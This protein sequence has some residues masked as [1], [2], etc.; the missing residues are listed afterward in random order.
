MLL[1]NELYDKNHKPPKN[2]LLLFWNS[3]TYQMFVNFSNLIHNE[4]GLDL[5]KQFYTSKFGWSYK[6]CKS[7]IDVINNVHILNDGFMI[8][9]IIVKSESDVEKAISYINSLFTPEFIDKIEQKIIQRNQKQR[10]RSKRLL[11]REKNEKN[12]FLENVNPK[13]LNKFIWSPRISQSKIR[14]LYQTNAKGICDD[15][16][17][18]EVGFTLYARCLQGRDEH[19]LANEGK[20]KCHHCRKVNISPS[21][22]LIICSC[23]YAY[24]FREYM[25]SFNKDGMLS[26]SATPFFNK[27]IDMWS[28]ANTYYDKIKAIDFVIHECHLNM[29]S[30]VTRGFAGRNLIEGTGEQLHELI[31]SLAYK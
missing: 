15:V 26:R 20:L 22:G 11:E 5:T 6:F 2:S 30:G 8:N 27:F 4:N 14:S 18:D 19:L 24:I 9:D 7:S 21:N 25:R 28:I 3:K 12:D 31:L 13:M 1:W 17:V 29:M 16:L 10:E 23:G